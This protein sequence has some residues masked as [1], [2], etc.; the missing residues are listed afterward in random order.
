MV[1]VQH[2]TANDQRGY[3]SYTRGLSLGD[4]A[5][6]LAQVHMFDL[7]PTTVHQ[8]GDTIFRIDA[9]RAPGMI[10]DC[11]FHV[12]QGFMC[13]VCEGGD[14]LSGTNIVRFPYF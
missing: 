9:D 8:F 14:V 1:D 12:L 5:A 11:L 3:A 4:T 7:V 2:I 13:S 10:E 6:V